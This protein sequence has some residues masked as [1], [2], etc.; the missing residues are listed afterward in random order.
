MSVLPFRPKHRTSSQT[1]L[2]EPSLYQR[3]SGR[4]WTKEEENILVKLRDEGKTCHEI[5]CRLPHRSM[6][7]C[8]HRFY[9]KPEV[10][11]QIKVATREGLTCEEATRLLQLKASQ[12]FWRQIVQH[13][14]GR[15][16]ASLKGHCYT[17]SKGSETSR[18]RYRSDED[19]RLLNLRGEMRLPWA[20][21]ARS[22]ADRSL[23]SLTSRHYNR[24]FEGGCL[25][26]DAIHANRAPE[27]GR[28]NMDND[29][30]TRRPL[31]REQCSRGAR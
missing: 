12:L 23:D 30:E 16:A 3:S 10:R 17:L 11:E 6:S 25:K 14:P 7:A 28:C 29:C 21:V 26:C 19:A 2:Q 5:R 24:N 18:L 20:E 4:R 31:Q 13:F 8:C 15:T 27:S 9:G 22:F 1:A